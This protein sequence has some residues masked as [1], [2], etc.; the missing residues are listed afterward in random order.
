MAGSCAADTSQA[1]TAHGA[2]RGEGED[3]CGGP[4]WVQGEGGNRRPQRP[5]G[6]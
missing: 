4:P 1:G 5:P 3:P 2:G 6:E